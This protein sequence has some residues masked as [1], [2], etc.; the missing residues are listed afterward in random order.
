[1]DSI[2]KLAKQNVDQVVFAMDSKLPYLTTYKV[3]FTTIMVVILSG[4]K[5]FASAG[6]NLTTQQHIDLLSGTCGC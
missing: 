4:L 6:I 3:Y 1:M 2:V 5:Y